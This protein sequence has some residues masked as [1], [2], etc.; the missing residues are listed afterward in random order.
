MTLRVMGIPHESEALIP[1]DPEHR[2]VDIL[3]SLPPAIAGD[4]TA[5]ALEVDGEHHFAANDPRHELGGTVLRNRQ[6]RKAGVR[7]A[8]TH[9]MDWDAAKTMS[10][11][12]TY[13]QERLIAA[14][15]TTTEIPPSAEDDAVVS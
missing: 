6:L 1:G 12:Q 3:V 9:F 8:F 7:L 10:E 4:D 14:T 15:T 2:S 11:R 13:L 5:I